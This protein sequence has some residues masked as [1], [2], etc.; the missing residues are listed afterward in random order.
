LF[1]QELERSL[2]ILDKPSGPLFEPPKDERREDQKEGE[3][4]YGLRPWR[5]T[6]DCGKRTED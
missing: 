5:H 1:I 4:R 6:A 2:A 3:K